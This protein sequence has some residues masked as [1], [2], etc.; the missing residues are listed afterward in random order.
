M[1]PKRRI[2]LARQP[3]FVWPSI[4]LAFDVES[5]EMEDIYKWCEFSWIIFGYRFIDQR[6]TI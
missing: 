1:L 2:E 6:L 5:K 4:R 3:L